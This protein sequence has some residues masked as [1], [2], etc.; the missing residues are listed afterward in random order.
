MKF[1]YEIYLPR[2]YISIESVILGKLFICINQWK[3]DLL[4]LHLR[5]FNQVYILFF[6]STKQRSL[7][8][9]KKIEKVLIRGKLSQNI[10]ETF[11]G[12]LQNNHF[13][14]IHFYNCLVKRYRIKLKKV[15]KSPRRGIEPRSPAWQ[16]GIL[17]TILS[18]IGY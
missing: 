15:K 14:T 16:A 7:N 6:C 3:Y 12:W 2:F 1:F 4:Y 8:L 10:I 9:I 11:H 5:R 18:R 17:T 13:I